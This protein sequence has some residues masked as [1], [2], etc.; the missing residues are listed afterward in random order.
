[1]IKN[2]SAPY[3]FGWALSLPFGV[4]RCLTVCARFT[5]RTRQ[6]NRCMQHY[7]FFLHTDA[8]VLL[9]LFEAQCMAF[10]T[11]VSSWIM[12]I[13]PLNLNPSCKQQPNTHIHA[14]T[15]HDCWS[16]IMD[17]LFF[18][19]KIFFLVRSVS[20]LFNTRPSEHACS[21]MPLTIIK[22]YYVFVVS[23]SQLKRS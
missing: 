17:W 14:R 6:H 3:S 13:L 21:W 16:I 1:M 2:I 20:R 19:M 23:P 9:R 5:Y 15:Q 7:F 22:F 10:C 12:F 8:E 18:Y 11:Q 4:R